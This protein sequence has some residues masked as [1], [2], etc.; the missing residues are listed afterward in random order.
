MFLGICNRV[1]GSTL[2]GGSWI[3]LDKVKN[4]QL[5]SVARSNNTTTASTQFQ[6]DLG[7]VQAIKC[8]SIHAHNL[9]ANA[10][11]TLRYHH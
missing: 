11:I 3:A 7:S 9:T 5:Y 4:R 2:S 6:I 1:D 8:L 10:T